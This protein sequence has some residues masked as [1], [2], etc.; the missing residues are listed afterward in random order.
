MAEFYGCMGAQI[1]RPVHFS[2]GAGARPRNSRETTKV[3]RNAK[4]RIFAIPAAVPANAPKPRI[5]A[6]I[7]MI[8]NVQTHDNIVQIL[9]SES[10]YKSKFP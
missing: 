4:K 9:L 1:L 8:K 6:M 2:Y 3:I 7:A 5:A 10:R